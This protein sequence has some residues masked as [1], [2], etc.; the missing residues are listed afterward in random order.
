MVRWTLVLLGTYL[1][2]AGISIRLDWRE[3]RAGEGPLAIPA[4]MRLRDEGGLRWVSVRG[5]L[6]PEH[7]VFR[8]GLARPAFTLCAPGPVVPV[9]EPSSGADFSALL[10]CR[11][12][13]RAP[14]AEEA[15]VLRARKHSTARNSSECFLLVRLAVTEPSLWVLSPRI[16]ASSPEMRKRWYRAE[17]SVG[18]LSRFRDL[19]SNVPDLEH[20]TESVR[21]ALRSEWGREVPPDAYVVLAEDPRTRLPAAGEVES[22][23]IPVQGSDYGLFVVASGRERYERRGAIEGV[24]RPISAPVLLGLEDVLDARLPPLVGLIEPRPFEEWTAE[25]LAPA[26][27]SI[28]VGAV[29]IAGAALLFL[30]H[31]RRRRIEREEIRDE[32]ARE[33][34][35]RASGAPRRPYVAD[36]GADTTSRGGLDSHESVW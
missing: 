33:M 23:W 9:L 3:P 8:T 4:V 21:R 18:R 19:A 20:D 10:G 12:E 36:L 35:A 15:L 13:V 6:E 32:V 27:R 16:P 29:V 25:R 34:S 14:P 28:E 7:T 26:D 22:A 30:V 17:A 1:L 2:V 5:E 11:V 24:L 31:A